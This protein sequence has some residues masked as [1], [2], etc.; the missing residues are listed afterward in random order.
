MNVKLPE[1]SLLLL[2]GV[3]GA[4]KSTFAKRHFLPTE[5]V[6][7]DV[8]RGL[9]SDDQNDQKSTDLAF[10][11]LQKMIDIRLRNRKLT[12]VDAT[13]LRP[14]DR[15]RLRRLALDNDTL[16]AVLLFDTPK[17]VCKERNA[18]RPDR[19]FGGRVIDR[20]YSLF[21]QTCRNIKKEKFHRVYRIKPED[22]DKVVIDRTKLWCDKREQKGPFDIIGDIHGCASELE[23]LLLQLGY[24]DGAHPEGRQLIFVGDIT[25]RGPR[26]IDCLKI[27]RNAVE[28][29]GA[30]CA[31]SYTHLTLP[32]NREV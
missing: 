5:V 23:E 22:L 32:T 17:K 15:K 21:N 8:C 1:I 25:D 19:Q 4:G 10:E 26:N 30:L 29:Q 16:S 13:N 27:V 11:L 3:S 14:E 20:Q 9:V 24:Q 2:V 31:V 18:N 6:S 12:V 7:S 28:N